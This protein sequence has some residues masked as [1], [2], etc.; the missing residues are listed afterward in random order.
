MLTAQEYTKVISFTPLKL[1]A[2]EPLW[3]TR[4]CQ[5]KWY[6]GSPKA[7]HGLTSKHPGQSQCHFSKRRNNIYRMHPKQLTKELSTSW[8]ETGLHGRVSLTGVVGSKTFPGPCCMF[9]LWAES[10]HLQ[11]KHR[12]YGPKVIIALEPAPSLVCTITAPWRS[13]TAMGHLKLW[14]TCSLKWQ[15]KHCLLQQLFKLKSEHYT[16]DYCIFRWYP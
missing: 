11:S 7:A 10:L 16:P 9:T 5:R 2:V 6:K 1:T 14:F 13:Y 4:V 8:C 3:V 12:Y 15:T